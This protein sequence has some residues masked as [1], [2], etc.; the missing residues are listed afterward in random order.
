MVPALASRQPMFQIHRCFPA[1]N[2]RS[3]IAILPVKRSC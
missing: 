3:R 1:L 2:M